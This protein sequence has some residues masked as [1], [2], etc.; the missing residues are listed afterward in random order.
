MSDEK[1]VA[2]A[3]RSMFDYVLLGATIGGLFV[4]STQVRQLEERL[5]ELESGGSAR[6]LPLDPQCTR[7]HEAP[8][9]SADV[10]AGDDVPPTEDDDAHLTDDD[11]DAILEGNEEE[12]E[13]EA[14]P[15]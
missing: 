13:E 2:A 9:G 7:T 11:T 10:D 14:P 15:G 5:L 8:C 6:Y 3:P 1:V 4:L 12:E